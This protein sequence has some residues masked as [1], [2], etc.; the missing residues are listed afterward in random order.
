MIKKIKK[1]KKTI[2]PPEKKGKLILTP[3]SRGK[4]KSTVEAGKNKVTKKGK[5]DKAPVERSMKWKYPSDCT[6]AADRKK[7]RAE[8]R[9]E[10]RKLLREHAAL[11]KDSKKSKEAAAKETAINALGKKLFLDPATVW[12]L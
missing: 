4:I 2:A 9:T 7:F 1:I 11:K 6:E 3:E 10:V 8:H 12:E 5:T